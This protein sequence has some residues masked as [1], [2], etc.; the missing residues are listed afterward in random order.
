MMEMAVLEAYAERIYA[1]AVKRTYTGEEAE[2]LSQEILFTLVKELPKL[3]EESRFEPWLWGV[4][5]NVSKSFRR[6]MGR[7]RATYAYDVPEDMVFDR[8]AQ[9]EAVRNEELYG[10][11]RKKIAMLSAMYR[12]IIILYY[13]DDLSVKEISCRLGIP[14]GTVTWRLAEARKKLREEWE[15]MDECAL[16]PIKMHISIYGEGNFDGV[17]IPFPDEYVKDALS[18]NILYYCSEKARNVEELAKL[19]GVPAY[20]VEERAA[21]LVKHEALTEQAKGRYRTEFLVW[22]D[23]FGR[24]CQENAEKCLMLVMEGMTAAL[25]Q[26]AG[27][28]AGLRIHRGERNADEL[29]YL[30]GVMAFRHAEKRYC[31]LPYPPIKEKRN[32]FRWEYLGSVET[33][34]YPRTGIGV[35]CSMDS[36]NGVSYNHFVYAAF[37]GFGYRRAMSGPMVKACEDILKTGEAQDEYG[38][39]Q[40]IQAGYVK[41]RPDGSFFV[42]TPAF[43]ME[44]KKEFDRIAE[45]CMAPLMKDYGHAVDAFAA[46]YKALFPRHLQDTADRMCRVIFSGLYSH[47]VKKLQDEGELPPPPSGAICDVLL[48]FRD[49]KTTI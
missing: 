20:Y 29:F 33:G 47:I 4:A 34:T 3:R 36:K 16:K 31:R 43:T 48:Q 42:T 11:L 21:H 40:A 2:E 10:C 41:R 35:Q 37:G 9:E 30:Y 15:D 46:G 23:R 12:N 27:Q 49:E 19:C 28:A 22:T 26:I 13:Y 38:A 45:T 39:S 32:G 1:Y 6:R 7:R 24:Y 17:N 8:D 44:Q 18:Q 5:G 25:K 14:E